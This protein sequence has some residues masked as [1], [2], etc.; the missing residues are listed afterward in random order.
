MERSTVNRIRN[1]LF[2]HLYGLASLLHLVLIIALPYNQALFAASFGLATYALLLGLHHWQ[3]N[4]LY[5]KTL[6][7]LFMNTYVFLLNIES[8]SAVTIIYFILPIVVSALYNNT[9]PVIALGLLT[10]AEIILLVFGFGIFER[11]ASLHYVHLALI[12]FL[13]IVLVLTILHSLYFSRIWAQMEMQNQTM[14]QALLSKEGYL[15][16]FFETAKDAIAVFDMQNRVI[17]INPAFETL[18]GW[19]PEDC[20]GKPLPI[21]PPENLTEALDRAQKVRNG[22]SF[23]LVETVDMKKNGTRFSAQITLSPIFD[24][25]GTVIATSVISR[26]ITFQKESEKVIVQSEKLKLA[27]EIAAGVAHEIRNPLT[28]ISGFV[29]MMD[30]APAY[31][32]QQYTKLI[33]SEIERINLIIGEFLVLAKPQASVPKKVSLRSTLTDLTALFGPEFNMRGIVFTQQWHDEDYFIEGEEHQL[34]QVFI[35]VFKNAIE[36]SHGQGK[37]CLTVEKSDEG[38]VSVTLYDNGNGI[39]P[40]ILEK[41]FEPFYTTKSTGT[42]LGLIISQKIVQEH[43]GQFTIISE[44]GLGTEAKIILPTI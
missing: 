24:H 12:V 25:T 1:I 3:K 2:I 26:D 43:G 44:E 14:E 4:D 39:S 23:S 30:S 16:L 37:L 13:S 33:R 19:T 7:L 20:M 40:E 29:Q 21:I 18:Y 22:E 11:S 41:I 6:T 38:F 28:V 15:Q 32:Y 10:F 5:V 35:N 36:A 31:P 34:K 17:A 8:Q 42:G 27:G 9:R